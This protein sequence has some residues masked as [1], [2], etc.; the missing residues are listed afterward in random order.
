MRH[1]P[2]REVYK[3]IFL[4]SSLW[5]RRSDATSTIFWAAS[6]IFHST[7]FSFSFFFE[8]VFGHLFPFSFF[9]SSSHSHLGWLHFVIPVLPR[10]L[11]HHHCRFFSFP[12]SWTLSST[13]GFFFL[14]P[15][16]PPIS[17]SYLHLISDSCPHGGNHDSR[18]EGSLFT[19]GK[20]RRKKYITASHEKESVYR[21][22]NYNFF[23]S[24]VFS[25][26]PFFNQ[27]AQLCI[28]CKLAFFP[29]LHCR[30]QI[31]FQQHD[32]GHFNSI[33]PY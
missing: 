30:Q 31:I 19:S 17:N 1:M 29:F 32:K 15:W 13:T 14:L 18:E 8:I 26:N 9:S 20:R 2:E 22:R 23:S 28:I 4:F 11:S 33:K 5:R 10:L 6:P 16:H 12:R 21:R 25:S 24:P 7:Y 3:E 27:I